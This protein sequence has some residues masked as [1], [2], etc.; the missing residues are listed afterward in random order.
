M[1]S[2]NNNPL[3]TGKIM[4]SGLLALCLVAATVMG[5]I[6]P[7][8]VTGK[9]LASDLDPAV[10]EADNGRFVRMG[11]NKSVVIRLPAEARDVVVGNEEIVDA[12]V[13][14]KNTAYLFARKYGQTNIFFFDASGRQIL[15][16]DLEVAVDSMALKRL[17]NRALPGN[18]LT[19][20]TAERNIVLAGTARN[21]LEAEQAV[22]LANQYVAGTK[23][24]ADRAADAFIVNNIKIIGQDQVMLKVKV[25]EIKRSVLKQFGIDWTAMLNIGK[26]AFDLASINPFSS[27]LISPQGYSHGA[28]NSTNVNVDAWIT[29]MEGDGLVRT[30]AEPNLTALTGQSAN[31]QAGGEFPFRSCPGS[32]SDN[33]QIEFKKF[34]VLV[35]FTP[36]VLTE[37]RINL[38]IR[39]EV[40]DIAGSIDGIPSLDTRNATTVLELPSGGSMMLGGL[41]RETSRA[42]ING[43]P[44]LKK[45][46]VLGALFRSHDFVNNET[47]LV[48]IATPFLVRPTAERNL[49]SP[50]QGFN[51]PTDKQ[52]AFLGRLNKVYGAGEV[53]VGT[54][55][56]NVGFIVE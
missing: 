1:T 34:G 9:A 53:P 16:V 28:Y 8:L 26:F 23:T 39:T 32:N 12:V 11:L 38:K 48:I 15:S 42:N 49:A 40:S 25:V 7:N 56:G 18:R 19:V 50:D 55:H 14:S 30:L 2:L 24:G 29:A 33:C 4:K 51:P 10:E 43:T 17:L 20:D 41:I 27:T 35:D 54:Y 45:L 5:A 3:F 21:P 36:T 6:T 22:E 31:F 37:G 52:A 47:E 46:P 13:R 44:G